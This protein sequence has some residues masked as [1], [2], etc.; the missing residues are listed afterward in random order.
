MSFVLLVVNFLQCPDSRTGHG[1]YIDPHSDRNK[2]KTK[3]F[4][5]ILFLGFI[6]IPSS[7]SQDEAVSSLH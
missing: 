2:K 1:V 6:I 5:N 3:Y 7:A 4:I